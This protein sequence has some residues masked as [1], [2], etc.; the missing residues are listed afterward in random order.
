MER[1]DSDRL[2]RQVLKEKVWCRK[3]RHDYPVLAAE[4]RILCPESHRWGQVCNRWRNSASGVTGGEPKSTGRLQ[5]GWWEDKK[6]P[7][8]AVF[9]VKGDE[10]APEEEGDGER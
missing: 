4:R 7:S 6:L 10:V 5:I 8:G 9:L 3:E 1:G 2:A